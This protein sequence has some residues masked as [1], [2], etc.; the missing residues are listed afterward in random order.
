MRIEWNR[1]GV[2]QAR[3]P[4]RPMYA[5]LGALAALVLSVAP[6]ASSRP[7]P[8]IGGPTTSLQGADCVSGSDCWAVGLVVNRAG[9]RLNQA[10]RWNGTRWRHVFTPDPGGKA[11]GDEQELARVSCVS[12]ADCWAV[13]VYTNTSSMTRTNEAL[14]WNG[15]RWKLISTPNPGGTRRSRQ[16]ELLGVSCVSR[17]DCWAVGAA[18]V[19]G[20][21]PGAFAAATPGGAALNQVLHWNGRRWSSVAVHDPAGKT[22]SVSNGLEGVACVK[23]SDCW[24]VGIFRTK[25]GAILNQAQRF[26]GKKW[27][28]V[29]TP[30]PGEKS[31]GTGLPTLS[32]QL[33]AVACP[34]AKACRAVGSYPNRSGL[35]LNEALRFN[36]K[37][38]S[39]MS[40]PDQGGKSTLESDQLSGIACTAPSD[41][42]AVGA[43]SGNSGGL[44]NQALRWDGKSWS[45]VRTPNPAGNTAHNQL[46]AI[47]CASSKDCWAVGNESPAMSTTASDEMLHWNGRTWKAG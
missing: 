24:A 17:S 40:T 26:N 8:V 28:L 43:F 25:A 22:G 11:G 35:T 1:R 44:L 19:F 42:W 3:V 7:Y 23:A 32:R 5:V 6:L 21:R 14:H 47:A 39:V 15:K 27:K 31:G 33:P 18:A 12:A 4:L 30:S 13:G 20:V 46:E 38:W 29:S 2:V 9:A 41:C 34:S 16:H 10:M 36:G 37:K 45:L